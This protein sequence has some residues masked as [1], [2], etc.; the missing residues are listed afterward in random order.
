MFLYIKLGIPGL[1]FILQE[2]SE[3]FPVFGLTENKGN[4]AEIFRKI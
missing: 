3:R 1:G 4:A 2:K